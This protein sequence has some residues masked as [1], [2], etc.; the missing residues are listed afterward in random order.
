MS[1]NTLYLMQCVQLPGL[2]IKSSA[3]YDKNA[4]GVSSNNARLSK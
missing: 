2:R 3:W 1:T 4:I